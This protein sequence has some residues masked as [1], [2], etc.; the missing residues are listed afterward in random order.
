MLLASW[1]KKPRRKFTESFRFSIYAAWRVGSCFSI[2]EESILHHR[3]PVILRILEFFSSSFSRKIHNPWVQIAPPISQGRYIY[4][5]TLR[6]KLPVVQSPPHLQRTVRGACKRSSKSCLFEVKTWVLDS[7]SMKVESK[8]V[9][10][11]N[12]FPSYLFFQLWFSGKSSK[13]DWASSDDGKR[14]WSAES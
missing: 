8:L 9:L 10:E 7:F 6:T 12:R 13:N 4:I 5:Y 3:Y 14:W 2:H 1:K 11:V